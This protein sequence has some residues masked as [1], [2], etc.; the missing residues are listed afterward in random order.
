MEKKKSQ[1]GVFEHCIH[2]LS[3]HNT[4]CIHWLYCCICIN[5]VQFNDKLWL[6][7][8]NEK[9]NIREKEILLKEEIMVSYIIFISI[10]L[11]IYSPVSSPRSSHLIFFLISSMEIVTCE[12]CLLHIYSVSSHLNGI[13][14]QNFFIF[15]HSMALEVVLVIA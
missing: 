3:Y 13:G 10:N 15:V 4:L 12:L 11:S 1:K 2:L 6:S 9:K 14:F 7:E 5:Q 8:K